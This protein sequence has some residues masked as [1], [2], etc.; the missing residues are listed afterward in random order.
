MPLT[1]QTLIYDPSAPSCNLE[2][3]V[4]FSIIDHFSR[5]DEKQDFVVGTLLGMEEGGVV[6]ICSSFPVPHT[7]VEDQIALN[8][9]FHATMLSL[10]QRVTPK[11]KVVGW[12]STGAAINETTSLFH[13]FYGQDVERPVHLL[14]DLGLGKQ[15]MSCKAY[16]SVPLTLGDEVATTVFRDI[17]LTV[18]SGESDRAGL[19]TLL[20]MT[21]ERPAE[22]SAA[23][24]SSGGGGAAELDSVEQT[25]K[26][27]LRT[28]E[29]ACLRP[30]RQLRLG[31]PTACARARTAGGAEGGCPPWPPRPRTNY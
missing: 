1:D 6:T 22:A 16:V 12:Y 25:V 20:K 7:E 14:F 19:D 2:P 11:L 5:R 9:D 24:G 23:G 15:R 26:K 31:R 3:A 17:A 4:L 13:E 8:S 29:G 21:D 30:L 18:V 10:Q 28:L 27:L